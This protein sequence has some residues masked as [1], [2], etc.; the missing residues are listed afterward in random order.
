VNALR[1]FGRPHALAGPLDGLADGLV[2]QIQ[3]SAAWHQ[4]ADSTADQVY[5]RVRSRFEADKEQIANEIIAVATPGVKQLASDTMDAERGKIIPIAV[6]GMLTTI[7]GTW[8]LVRYA[9]NR[10]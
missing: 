9:G 7:V 8:L 2:A 5:D 1:S 6:A 4:M 3:G 10:G